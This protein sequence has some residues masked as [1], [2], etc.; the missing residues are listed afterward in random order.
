MTSIDKG[1]LE[2]LA[3]RAA[4]AGNGGQQQGIIRGRSLVLT[5]VIRMSFGIGKL[6]V[7]KE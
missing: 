7:S 4:N 1:G 3:Q 6:Q 2:L 5:R